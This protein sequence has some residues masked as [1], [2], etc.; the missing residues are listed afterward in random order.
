[1][2]S[3][4]V[5]RS[6]E[7]HLFFGRIMKEHSLFLRAGF[8]PASPSFSEK[9]EHF[10]C[11]FEKL[12]CEAVRLANGI[13]SQQMLQSQE[14]VRRMFS[15]SLDGVSYSDGHSVAHKLNAI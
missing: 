13:V 14:L 6:L 5:E 4:Y 8:T 15:P 11:E 2:H 12:L 1:M 9:A 7:L 3:G 10:K